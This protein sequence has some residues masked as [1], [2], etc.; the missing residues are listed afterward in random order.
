[1][2]DDVVPSLKRSHGHPVKKIR[3]YLD[4][5]RFITLSFLCT[6]QDFVISFKTTHS[7]KKIF[8][9]SRKMK[10]WRSRTASF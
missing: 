7:Y 1:M 2:S 6:E 5:F 4:G 3:N 8:N 9:I 10:I